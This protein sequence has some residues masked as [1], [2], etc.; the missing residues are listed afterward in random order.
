MIR[1]IKIM[2]TIKH[3]GIMKLFEVFEDSSNIFLVLELMQGS[4]KQRKKLQEADW[5][6][7]V[8]QVLKTLNHLHDNNIIHRDIKV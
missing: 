1:E 8:F 7:I 6:N 5:A 4:L 3:P 2:R